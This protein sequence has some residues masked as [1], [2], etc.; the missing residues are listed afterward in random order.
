MSMVTAAWMW[1]RPG[2]RATGGLRF[3]RG[4]GGTWTYSSAGLTTTNTFRGVTFGD[5]DLDGKPELIASRFGFPGPSGGGLF[6]YKY[7]SGAN[8]WS[9]APNQIP[10]TNSYYKLALSDLNN[11]GWPDLVAGG[12][13]TT[14]SAGLFTYLG[15]STGFISVTPPITSGSLDRMAVGDFDR[16]GLP[17][18]GAADNAGGGVFAWSDQGVRDPIGAWTLIASPQITDSPRAL[19][20]SRCQSRRRHRRDLQSRGRQRV[21][22][23]SGRR[24]QCVDVLPGLQHGRRRVHRHV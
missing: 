15:S 12:G 18:I 2:K 13:S 11:D 1:S 16:N 24:R 22:Y 8:T 23:V 5:V 6:I 19:A 7:D 10:L 4:S 21:E 14:G 17:D 3:W 20:A 9:L